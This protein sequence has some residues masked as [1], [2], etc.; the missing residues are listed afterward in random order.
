MSNNINIEEIVEDVFSSN[1]YCTEEKYFNKIENCLKNKGLSDDVI[2]SHKSKIESKVLEKFFR[3][4]FNVVSDSLKNVG[5]IINSEDYD[6]IFIKK[7]P[8]SDIIQENK[9][10]KN[11]NQSDIRLSKNQEGMFPYLDPPKAY[12]DDPRFN[13]SL[14]NFYILKIPI[15]LNKSNLYYL[16]NGKNNNQE[17]KKLESY[18]TIVKDNRE[19]L[20]IS[21]QYKYD[22]SWF[23]K[24]RKLLYVND[25]LILLKNKEKFNYEAYAIKAKDGE[26]INKNLSKTIFSHLKKKTLVDINNFKILDDNER[27]RLSDGK[28]ILIYGVPGSGKSWTIKN[29]YCNDIS[30]ME[31]VVFHP[32]YTYSDFIGQ[33]LPNVVDGQ[34][35]YKFVPGPFTLIL[36]KA[37]ENYNQKYYLVI[38]EINR[39]NAPAIFGDIFQL[40]DRKTEEN[41]DDYPIGTSEYEITNPEIAKVVY[42]DKEHKIRIPSNLSILATMNTS[43]Q[44]VFTLD[45][46]F[47]RRWSMELINN[48]FDN[49]DDKFKNTLI[50]DTNVT[51]E[52]FCTEINNLIIEKNNLTLSSEDKRMGKY[53][54]QIEDLKDE[55]RFAEK[56]LKY[57]WDDVFKFSREEIFNVDQLSLEF[58]IN[59]FISSSG[60]NRFDIF[61]DNVKNNLYNNGY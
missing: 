32:D 15:I 20:V 40:L 11:S 56:V 58:V 45:T 35:T 47:Q 6:A 13:N 24:F 29:K 9:E 18:T 42:N 7:L 30:H 43:D 5:T 52:K 57:L 46:A 8:D 44:N 21:S 16:E 28:N 19:R 25:Y 36:K 49:V 34:I 4:V 54:V 22:G 60:M 51:W 17:N 14:K 31:R 48:N 50:L 61:T 59:K 10:N 39:G 12:L 23:K 38:E 3:H 2:N 33:I 37:Y 41:D 53:F 26:K 27:N 1:N 55:N